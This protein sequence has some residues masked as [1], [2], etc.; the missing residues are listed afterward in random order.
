[1][2]DVKDP[3]DKMFSELRQVNDDQKAWIAKLRELAEAVEAHIDVLPNSRRKSLALT[4]LESS[5]LF[6]NKAATY[7]K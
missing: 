6:A 3:C 1:M 4:H 7:G 5:V 2:L